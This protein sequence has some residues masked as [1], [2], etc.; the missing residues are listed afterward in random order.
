MTRKY[1]TVLCVSS[2]NVYLFTQQS[3]SHV[4]QILYKMVFTMLKLRTQQE[5]ATYISLFL[6]KFLNRIDKELISKG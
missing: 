1:T 6:C 2:K 5:L 3:M 4:G